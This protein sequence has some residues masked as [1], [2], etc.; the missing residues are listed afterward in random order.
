MSRLTKRNAD[1]TA[2]YNHTTEREVKNGD[3]LEKLAHY[4]DLEEAGRTERRCRMSDKEYYYY[5]YVNGTSSYGSVIVDEN[6]TK[7][8]IEQAIV[9]DAVKDIVFST[10]EID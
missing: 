4:E 9:D 8:E 5:I 2:W 7:E 3:I 10:E 1:G 6:A